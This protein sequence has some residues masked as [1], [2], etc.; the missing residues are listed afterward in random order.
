MARIERIKRRLDNWAIW[1]ARGAGGAL[2]YHTRNILAV[3][4]WARGA[5]NGMMIPV[6]EHEAEETDCAVESFRATRPQVYA[7]LKRIY[8]LDL[9]VNE[10]ARRFGIPKSTVCSHLER[11]D[12]AIDMWLQDRAAEKDKQRAAVEAAHAASKRSFTP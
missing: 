10:T 9:G 1:K 8:L 2:G 12:A 7:T 3:D 6:F 5:Y 4:V 11:A